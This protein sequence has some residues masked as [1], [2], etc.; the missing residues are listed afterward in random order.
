MLWQLW[1]AGRF[2]EDNPSLRQQYV[3]RLDHYAFGI[4]I[5]E[6]GGSGGGDCASGKAWYE[7]ELPTPSSIIARV[8]LAMQHHRTELD[9]PFLWMLINVPR[10]LFRVVEGSGGCAACWRRL[11][12][13]E[14]LSMLAPD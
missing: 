11:T 14:P 6:V 10:G 2:L 1:H 12:I 13:G 3:E 9:Y 7:S 4:L 8:Q 5:C